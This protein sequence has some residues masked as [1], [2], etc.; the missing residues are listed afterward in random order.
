VADKETVLETLRL[1]ETC[2][3]DLAEEE[4]E[5]VDDE[6]DM[7]VRDKCAQ[8]KINSSIEGAGH[9]IRAVRITA[10]IFG[11][12]SCWSGATGTDTAVYSNSR[13]VTT[14]AHVSYFNSKI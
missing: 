1:P 2:K 12:H 5:G 6:E 10:T 7:V 8:W 14:Q 4:A 3:V 9:R 11:D 13:C